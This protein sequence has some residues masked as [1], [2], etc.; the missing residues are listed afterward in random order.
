MIRVMVAVCIVVVAVLC[1]PAALVPVF[2]SADL[3]IAA[4]PIALVS[5]L[6]PRRPKPPVGD[7]GSPPRDAP[8]VNA[9]PTGPR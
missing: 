5:V 6:W 8:H 3:V 7:A 9:S 2:N 1:T 4:A